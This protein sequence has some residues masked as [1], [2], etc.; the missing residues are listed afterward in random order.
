MLRQYKNNARINT[1][2]LRIWRV[3]ITVLTIFIIIFN[4][5]DIYQVIIAQIIDP[6]QLLPW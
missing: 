2:R 5:I 1:R 4:V 6:F 3:S